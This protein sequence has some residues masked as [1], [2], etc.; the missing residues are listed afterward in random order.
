MAHF[1]ERLAERA[2]KARAGGMRRKQ[3]WELL[4]KLPKAS[5]GVEIGTWEG[6][7]AARLLKRTRP[8][9]LYLI[10]PWEYRDDGPYA[11]AW[12]GAGRSGGQ[13]RMDAIY[14]GV[15]ER[16]EAQIASGQVVVLRSRS[17]DAAAQLELLDWVYV[18]G[19]HSYEGVKADLEAFYRKLKPGGIIAGDDYGVDGWW[20]DGL[21]RA[22]DDFASSCDCRPVIMGDQ[23]LFAKPAG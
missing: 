23:F 5:V 6:D 22:V 18:D 12:F 11:G 17:A 4:S 1:G 9:R 14:E 19:D 8:K 2:V 10:D 13:A 21:I 20:R 15:R 3:R 7:F 16:F